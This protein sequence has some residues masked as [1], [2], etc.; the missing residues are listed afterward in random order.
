MQVKIGLNSVLKVFPV[1]PWT[2]LQSIKRS[3]VNTE[4]WISV[5]LSELLDVCDVVFENVDPRR[6]IFLKNVLKIILLVG[7]LC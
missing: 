5:V 3:S 4:T 2:C 6:L 1:G 7:L